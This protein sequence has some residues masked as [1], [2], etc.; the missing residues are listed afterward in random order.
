MVHAA[1]IIGDRWVLLI[2]REAFYGVCRFEDMR[3]D[4]SIPRSALTD[5][6]NRLVNDGFLEKFQYQED[7][8][9]KR[10]AYRLTNKGRSLAPILVAMTEWGMREKGIAQAHV[11]ICDKET[12]E[13]LRLRPV[14]SEGQSVS[15]RNVVL[16]KPS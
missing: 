6:L 4:L 16:G 14:N 11:Q 3:A 2:L 12:G 8:E 7:G 13:A 9:R 15:W 1:D 5:R 10:S